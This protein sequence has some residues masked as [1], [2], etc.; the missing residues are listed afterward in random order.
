MDFND[1]VDLPLYSSSDGSEIRDLVV[2][3]KS[4]IRNQSLAEA[5][6][7]FGTCTQ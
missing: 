3:R 1:V 2:Y 6:V 5:R 7:P 4:A